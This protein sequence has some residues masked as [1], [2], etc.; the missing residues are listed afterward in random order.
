MKRKKCQRQKRRR[1]KDLTKK[2][3]ETSKKVMMMREIETVM[4]LE[5]LHLN[6]QISTRKATMMTQTRTQRNKSQTNYQNRLQNKL[7]DP[8]QQ[9]KVKHLELFNQTYLAELELDLLNPHKP[10]K[11][12]KK[13]QPNSTQPIPI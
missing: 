5:D 10:A 11:D 13:P 12:F 3:S 9:L 1:R 7:T 4:I 6:N 8:N 2:S